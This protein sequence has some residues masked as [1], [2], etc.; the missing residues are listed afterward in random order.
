MEAPVGAHQYD[1]FGA[2]S[3]ALLGDLGGLE[4][5]LEVKLLLYSLCQLNSPLRIFQH[6]TLSLGIGC[7]TVE[8]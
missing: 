4:G 2:P 7:H 6:I 1:F 3:D 8:C 5:G